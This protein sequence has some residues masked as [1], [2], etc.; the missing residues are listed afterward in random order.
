MS[1]NKNRRA[2]NKDTVEVILIQEID[3]K[4]I[5]K[6]NIGE[7]YIFKDLKTEISNKLK[8]HFT[9]RNFQTALSTFFYLTYLYRF[10]PKPASINFN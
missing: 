5:I 10:V 1:I 9:L 4:T 2:K 7:K 3:Y 6:K 8:N